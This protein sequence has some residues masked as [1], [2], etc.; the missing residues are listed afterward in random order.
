MIQGGA[1]FVAYGIVDSVATVDGV[2][3]QKGAFDRL[4]PG[5][6]FEVRL[7]DTAFN[8]EAMAREAKEA[9]GE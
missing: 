3:G 2:E 5:N 8:Q 6:N 4:Q 9:A 7:E 1:S